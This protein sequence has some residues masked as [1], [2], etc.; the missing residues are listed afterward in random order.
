MEMVNHPKHYQGCSTLTRDLALYF[1]IP[2]HLDRECID[3]IEYY[4]LGF[5]VG[6]ALKYIWRCGQKGD[7]IEDLLKAKWYLQRY[8]NLKGNLWD[9]TIKLIDE[10]I[11]ELKNDNT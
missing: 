4:S 5:H 3:V 7:P 1:V 2:E 8:Q 10:K 6:N 9:V 11:K